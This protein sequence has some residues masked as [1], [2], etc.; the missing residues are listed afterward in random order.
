MR[1][2]K[3]D[4]DFNLGARRY[5]N[6]LAFEKYDHAKDRFNIIVFTDISYKR[7]KATKDSWNKTLN[8]VSR[9]RDSKITFIT[10]KQ[11]MDMT[12]PWADYYFMKAV[13]ELVFDAK[14]GTTYEAK[15]KYGS[16]LGSYFWCLSPEVIE[17]YP[18]KRVR[19]S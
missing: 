10:N 5:N 7:F 15:K 2:D 16:S 14:L 11:L 8:K 3:I 18:T 17:I 1:T 9:Y 6:C 13:R 12:H 4:S 19:R